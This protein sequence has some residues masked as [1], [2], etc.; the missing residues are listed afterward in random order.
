[1]WEQGYT[2]GAQNPTR[3]DALLD[4]YLVRP[5]NLFTSCRIIQGVSDHRGVLLEVEWEE[6]YCRPQMERLDPVYH[7]ADVIGLQKF[8]R[9]KF[10]IWASK[11]RSVE[12]VWNNFKNIILQCIEMFIPHKILRKNSDPEYY[13]EEVKKLKLKVR[14]AYNRRKSEHIVVSFLGSSLSSV[15]S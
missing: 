14:K 12:E 6:K 11:G 7:K 2:Q 3:G 4:V 13:N 10:A 9:D 5:E 8:L 15:S 1:V